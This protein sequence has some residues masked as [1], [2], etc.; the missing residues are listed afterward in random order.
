[1]TDP[2]PR[3]VRGVRSTGTSGTSRAPAQWSVRLPW[4][5]LALL[6]ALWMLATAAACGLIYLDTHGYATYDT[7]APRRTRPPDA[8]PPSTPLEGLAYQLYRSR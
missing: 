7:H 2:T 4:P 5:R 3:N 6:L 8:A 1:M